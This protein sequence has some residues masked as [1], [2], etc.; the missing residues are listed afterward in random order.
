MLYSNSSLKMLQFEYSGRV[1][2]RSK[3]QVSQG[4]RQFYRRQR[5]S[6]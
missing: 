5:L 3:P 6:K 4:A 1:S 2:S